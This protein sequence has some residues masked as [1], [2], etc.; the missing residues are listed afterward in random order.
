MNMFYIILGFSLIIILFCLNT[1]IWIAFSAGSTIVL[2]G[3]L[4]IPS[5]NIMANFFS[6]VDVFTL[7]AIPFFVLAGNVMAY[8]GA[9]IH[10][11]NFMNSF[12]GRIRGGIPIA[13]ILTAMVYA[14]ITGST[15]AT[16]VGINAIC[17]PNLRRAGYSD[18]F[19]AGMM[20]SAATLGQMIPPSLLMI[21]YGG[22]TQLD[23]GKLFLSGIV[24]GLIITLGL[25][26]TAYIK[27]PQLSELNVAF[28]EETFEWKNRGKYTV[29]ALPALLM[30]IIVLGSIYSGVM[31][32][33]EAGSLSCVYGFIISAFV[34]RGMKVKEFKHIIQ[35]SVRSNGMIMF[36]VSAATLF[37]L[38]LT[39][40]QLP[41]MLA[42]LITQ[43]N[44]SPRML[45]IVIVVFMLFLGCFLESTPILYLVIPIVLPALK[46]AGVSLIYFNVLTILCMEI[47]QI[48]PPF[49]TSMYFA[50]R[51]IGVPAADVIKEEIPYLITMIVCLIVF[52]FVPQFSLCLVH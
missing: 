10:I 23:V 18:K 16:L 2:F 22:L 26:I 24:P 52:I 43:Y 47:G 48:T 50:A 44:M 3:G 40:M 31:T 13:T 35:Q 42:T 30:P 20:C 37:A 41:Q 19:S 12:V 46:A 14:A 29:K 39:H 49:G 27:S 6:A 4:G 11:F 51:L 25:C 15:P 33:T 34:Y 7:M 9:S 8:G 45:V 32:P 28:P 17:L 1:P 5:S 36:I 21:I 38:A